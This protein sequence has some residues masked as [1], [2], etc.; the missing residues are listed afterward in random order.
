RSSDLEI[1]VPILIMTYMAGGSLTELSLQQL[2]AL[3]LANG[4][5]WRTAVCMVV[6]SLLHWPCATTLATIYRE[7]KSL[8]WTAASFLVPTLCGAAL[9]A[10]IALI[11]V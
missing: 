2:Q 9:C 6:F 7:T 4:W 1:V 11:P 5:T 8:K 3:L 10:L